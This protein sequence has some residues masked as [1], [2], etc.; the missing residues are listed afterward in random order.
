[1]KKV[2]RDLDDYLDTLVHEVRD[3][4]ENGLRLRTEESNSLPMIDYHWTH[5]PKSHAP[6]FTVSLY[7]EEE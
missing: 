6:I 3:A 7:E 5:H 2:P 4:F 1:M